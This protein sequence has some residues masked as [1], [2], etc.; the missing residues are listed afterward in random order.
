MIELRNIS[1]AFGSKVVLNG[2]TCAIPTGKTTCVIG[3]S[4][5]GK[6]VL[7]KHI[8]G[9]LHAD[10]G[11]VMIDGRDIESMSKADIFAMRRSVGYVFQGAA[12]F[13]SLSVFDNVVIGL[14]EHG[15][16]DNDILA[17]EGRRVL[18]AVGLLPEFK[19]AGTPAYEREFAILANKRPSD[20]SGGMRKRVGVARALVGKPDYIFYDEPTTG[21]DPVTSKQIDD[22]LQHVA[23]SIDVTS[24]VITHDMFSVYNIA[25]HVIML[26]EGKV[27]FDGTVA[28]L[29]ASK[30]PVVS[31]FLARFEEQPAL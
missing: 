29:R 24:V 28:E 10:S 13:D 17:N 1:K 22:L 7:L 18:S 11:S 8:V 2:V 15:E 12:L 20:L 27:Q 23:T 16:N 9:L 30:D 19:N 3:R 31:E 5:C 26:H 21:L 6:S 25:D 4:G 14:V